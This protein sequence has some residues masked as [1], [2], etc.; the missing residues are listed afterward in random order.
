MARG[1][2]P[3][4]AGDARE[5]QTWKTPGPLQ[6]PCLRRPLTGGSRAVP[7][8]K[9]F[10][11]D[12]LLFQ[13]TQLQDIAPRKPQNLEQVPATVRVCV[14]MCVWGGQG[15]AIPR[16]SS[17]H[18]YLPLQCSCPSCPRFGPQGIGAVAGGSSATPN[19]PAVSPV[20]SPQGALTSE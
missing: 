12:G 2:Y 6:S 4:D 15:S 14:R 8:S 16:V 3:N 18:S 7:D 20:E 13:S 9:R 1:Q 10:W 17:E 19:N 5:I 11:T